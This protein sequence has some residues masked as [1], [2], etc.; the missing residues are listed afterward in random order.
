MT[1]PLVKKSRPTSAAFSWT[2][3]SWKNSRIESNVS[4]LTIL[5]CSW[6]AVHIRLTRPACLEPDLKL[7]TICGCW[8]QDISG[9]ASCRCKDDASWCVFVYSLCDDEL[10]KPGGH[11][12]MKTKVG[13]K[14]LTF[15]CCYC[16]SVFWPKLYAGRG[17]RGADRASMRPASLHWQLGMTLQFVQLHLFYIL[18]FSRHMEKI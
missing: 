9:A 17:G 5:N 13:M 15:I 1:L 16:Y 6:L 4:T 18:T 10:K 14:C 8:H 7:Q 3:S 12:Q 11:S 2:S